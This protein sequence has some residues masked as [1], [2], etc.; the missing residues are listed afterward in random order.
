[1][2]SDQRSSLLE[3]LDDA[4][5]TSVAGELADVEH[6]VAPECADADAI[7]RAAQDKTAV[8][9]FAG[10]LRA[11]AVLADAPADA[12]RALQQFGERVG[13]A[14][15]LVDDL[16][17]AFG[18]PAQAGREAGAD[19][20]EAKRTPLVAL[21]RETAEWPRVSNALALAHTG[22]LAVR[23]AQDVLDRSG[24][25]TRLRTLVDETLAHADA[26]VEKSSLPPAVQDLLLSLTATLPRRIP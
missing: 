17:G 1:V 19:L 10:P 15:Q 11:G 3:I 23:E 22:P 6:S 8:Y 16:V 18:S 14:F 5:Y 7:L 25:R 12:M 9:S 24:A 4:V 26:E 21:A 13:L 20:R 2:S